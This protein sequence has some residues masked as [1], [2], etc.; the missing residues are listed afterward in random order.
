MTDTK[1]ST[2]PVGSLQDEKK[3]DDAHVD[4]GLSPD[5]QNSL[6]DHDDEFSSAEQ[7]KIIHRVDRRLI[8]T[9]GI[10]YCISLMDRT[11]LSAAAIAGMLVELRLTGYRYVCGSCPLLLAWLTCLQNIITLVFFTTYVAFQPPMTVLC[12]KIG[13]RPFLATITFCWGIVMVS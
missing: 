5:R 10:M 4:E 12:R 6:L 11:N 8:V 2:S 9:C 13:P 7:T 3:F 1:A